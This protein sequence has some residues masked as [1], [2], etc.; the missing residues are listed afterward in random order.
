MPRQWINALS[1][2]RF[3]NQGLISD[4]RNVNQLQL[5]LCCNLGPSHS[6]SFTNVNCLSWLLSEGCYSAAGETEE[7]LLLPD[8]GST[9]G[10]RWF[11]ISW[12]SRVPT[13]PTAR[14]GFL[15]RTA[16]QGF[17]DLQQWAI[18]ELLARVF[19]KLKYSVKLNLPEQVMVGCSRTSRMLHFYSAIFLTRPVSSWSWTLLVPFQALL[20]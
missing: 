12:N 5:C 8:A 9:A 14:R 7:Q 17:V 1:Q 18:P 6:N 19:S 3:L 11:R 13:Q 10:Q 20:Q 15:C 16:S 2:F 4:I